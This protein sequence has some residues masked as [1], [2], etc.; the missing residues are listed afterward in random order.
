LESEI[1]IRKGSKVA[2]MHG[3]RLVARALKREGV[4]CL[5][6][7]CGGHIQAIY[8][9]CLDEGIR[10]VDVRHEQSAAHAADG[11]ARVT[12]E[13]GVCAVTAGPGVTDAV[14]G[15]ANAFRSQVPMVII[16][17][18]GPH[19]LKDRGSL[20]EMDHVGLL[21]S[22]TKWSAQ[23]PEPKRLAEY[24]AWAFRVATTGVPGPV[25]LE[26]PLDHLMGWVQEDEAVW[27]EG[28][29]TVAQP[30][31]DPQ[32]LAEAA[33]LLAQAE[34]PVAVVGSQLRWS[35]QPQALERFADHFGIPVFLNGMARGGLPSSHPSFFAL[36][37]SA[38]STWTAASSAA[39]GGSTWD[40][41]PTPATSWPLWWRR[42]PRPH[43]WPTGYRR[44]GS[45]RRASSRRCRPRCTP[46]LRR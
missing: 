8:D 10:V 3:G 9:G 1:Q 2:T 21:R 15:V 44:S 27:P 23:V 18:Q 33:R 46:T 22:V 19:F 40:W 12:G 43:R 6:T 41:S 25:F 7:L 37:R 17:G 4:K 13:P 5:F 29:R 20:Q 24:V 34:R 42:W 11:W 14:T 45:R 30:A 39:T 16:G 36:S 32:L 38:T 35:R 26:M 31:P 28:Y